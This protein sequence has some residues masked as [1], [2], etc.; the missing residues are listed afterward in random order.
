MILHERLALALSAVT[1]FLRRK[2][3]VLSCMTETNMTPGQRQYVRPHITAQTIVIKKINDVP[4]STQNIGVY[5]LRP[6]RGN[7]H[8][9][10][11]SSHN[12]VYYIASLAESNVAICQQDNEIMSKREFKDR[13][14]FK[15]QS[16]A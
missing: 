16:T 12:T 1:F 3:T 13:F 14:I 5:E 11:Y 7:V 4:H 15:C 2:K 9:S 10:K 6:H 8:T